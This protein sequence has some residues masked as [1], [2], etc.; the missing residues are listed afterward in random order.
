MFINYIEVVLPK[1]GAVVHVDQMDKSSD[2]AVFGLEM[3]VGAQVHPVVGRVAYTVECFMYLVKMQGAIIQGL[4]IVMII[5]AGPASIV[6]P[7]KA[8]MPFGVRAVVQV[9]I[10]GVALIIEPRVLSCSCFQ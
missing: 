8:E 1:V 5:R 2:P 6:L 4:E 10:Y 7:G 9:G 3:A